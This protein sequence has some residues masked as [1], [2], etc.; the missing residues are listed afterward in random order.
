VSIDP[1][2]S[3][4]AV[5]GLDLSAMTASESIVNASQDSLRVQSTVH[6]DSTLGVR[7]PQDITELAKG[8]VYDSESASTRER[9]VVAAS[10]YAT[11]AQ[12]TAGSGGAGSAQELLAASTS[13]TQLDQAY[14]SGL[15]TTAF[16]EQQYLGHIVDH[17]A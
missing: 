14:A 4:Q 8:N 3:T 9:M 6:D 2:W 1:S 7:M 11:G 16:R 12:H 10:D 17:Q 13:A 5:T 15:A